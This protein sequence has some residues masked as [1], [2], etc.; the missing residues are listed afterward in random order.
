MYVVEEKSYPY[1][2]GIQDVDVLWKDIRGQL[3][4]NLTKG[5]KW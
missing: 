5:R 4:I 2:T 1:H 3:R